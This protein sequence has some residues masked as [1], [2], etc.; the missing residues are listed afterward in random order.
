[1][2]NLKSAG[3]RGKTP[4]EGT[5]PSPSFPPGRILVSDKD[6]A[7]EYINE[8]LTKDLTLAEIAH[9]AEM[10]PYYFSCAFKQS[11]GIP[12]HRYVMNSR[13]ERA[14]KLLMD[15]ELPLV[16]VGLSVG[17]QNQSHF[18]TLFHKRTG[19]TPKAFRDGI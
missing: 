9:V 1:M 3:E 8:N 18:T 7:I 16:E 13:I 2:I 6:G 15:D 10:N 14:K 17:F 5:K 4:A 11:T 19:V 12:P